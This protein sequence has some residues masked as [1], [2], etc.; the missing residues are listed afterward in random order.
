M[1]KCVR[2]RRKKRQ[3]CIGDLNDVIT[4][5]D[6]AITAP[7]MGVDATET[8][9]DSNPDVWAMI[10]TSAGETVFDGTDTE[11][12]VTHK[13]TIAFVDG[14]TAETWIL[15]KGTRIDILLLFCLGF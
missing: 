13:I 3:I 6:R 9:T 14:I 12:D 11:I 5:Q 15:F 7:L 10:E 4:L 8:F 1:P 2:I